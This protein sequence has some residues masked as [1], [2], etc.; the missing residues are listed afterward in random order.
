MGGTKDAV[1]PVGDVLQ[2]GSTSGV[3]LWLCCFMQGYRQSSL[4]LAEATLI[5]AAIFFRAILN[6]M[7]YCALQYSAIGPA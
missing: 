6:I 7:Q 5:G 3:M 4:A 2:V 1:V